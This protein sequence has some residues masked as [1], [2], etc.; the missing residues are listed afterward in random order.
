MESLFWLLGLGWGVSGFAACIVHDKLWAWRWAIIAGPLAFVLFAIPNSG[1]AWQ[2][3]LAGKEPDRGHFDGHKRMVDSEAIPGLAGTS[4]GSSMSAKQSSIY[5]R[6]QDSIVY[7][8]YKQHEFWY[9]IREHGV[10]EGTLLATNPDGP[11]LDFGNFLQQWS[12]GTYFFQVESKVNGPVTEGQLKLFYAEGRIKLKTPVAQSP[13]GPWKFFGEWDNFF[14]T[15]E[16]ENHQ[17]N[18]GC[19]PG[20]LTGN[21]ELKQQRDHEAARREVEA[22][23]IW[24]ERTLAEA[25][26][27]LRR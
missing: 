20:F 8:P 24:E 21:Q 27:W 17:P 25:R 22:R 14:P 1:A 19:S 15:A 12:L 3:R 10:G 18:L 23:R 6:N 26:K 2:A 9:L 16:L 13:L 7:G 4:K 11:W 5:Y